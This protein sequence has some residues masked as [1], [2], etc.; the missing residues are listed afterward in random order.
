M[1]TAA[2]SRTIGIDFGTSTT[3]VVD[4]L[5]E[6]PPAS[7]PLG[8]DAASWFPT[9]VGIDA[10]RQ[11]VVGPDAERLPDTQVIRSAKS[12]IGRDQ[13]WFRLWDEQQALQAVPV[14]DVIT[15][16]LDKVR[17]RVERLEPDFFVDGTVRMACPAM[18]SG[19]QR[20]RLAGLARRARIA[21]ADEHVIDEPIAAGLSYMRHRMVAK[22]SQPEGLL[23]VID[24]GGGTIDVA[25][26]EVA[27]HPGLAQLRTLLVHGSSD[28]GDAMDRA[29]MEWLRP[30]V[31]LVPAW[32]DPHES[33]LRR[34]LLLRTARLLKEDLSASEEAM[35]PLLGS[36]T[37]LRL[38]RSEMDQ[39]I[40][41]IVRGLARTVWDT[42]AALGQHDVEDTV[43]VR[44]GVTHVQL[45]GGGSRVPLVRSAMRKLFPDADVASDPLLLYPEASVATGLAYL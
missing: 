26:M 28:G 10:Q 1:S 45:A 34:A 8:E 39:A 27:G 12:A 23:L 33:D 35:R 16:V 44:R 41:P 42:V 29:V 40:A 36:Q 31:E 17:R 22:L 30:Q 6:E 20:S 3:M 2:R 37:L 19:E 14:D 5:G 9:L 21:V 13:E 24:V 18:W 7:L 15:L 32:K 4:R 43:S 38:T 11:W 25:V